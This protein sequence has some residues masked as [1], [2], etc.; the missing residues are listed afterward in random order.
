MKVAPLAPLV[1]S[2]VFASPDSKAAKKY[3]KIAKAKFPKAAYGYGKM[4]MSTSSMSMSIGPEPPITLKEC[5]ESFTDDQ[6]V[7][8]T[9][10]LNCGSLVGDQRDCALTLDGPLAELNCKDYTLSQEGTVET[11]PLPNLAYASGICLRNGAKAINCNVQQ[12]VSGIDV[13]NGGAEVVNSNLGSNF[14]GIRALFNED[15]TITIEDT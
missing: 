14:Y 12:F 9:D 3:G 7:V 15:S 8:L 1:L 4:C 5:G 11:P 13:R 6:K 2:S 10:N